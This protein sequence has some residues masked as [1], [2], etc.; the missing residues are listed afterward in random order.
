[1]TPY[2]CLHVLAVLSAVS[3][4]LWQANSHLSTSLLTKH[5]GRVSASADVGFQTSDKYTMRERFGVGGGVPDGLPFGWRFTWGYADN[6]SSAGF[7]FYPMVNHVRM[8]QSLAKEDDYPL[9]LVENPNLA[10]DAWFLSDPACSLLADKVATE[11]G[12]NPIRYA[13]GTRWIIGNET[14]WDNK[15]T[16]EQYAR[17]FVHWKACI[18]AIGRKHGRQYQYGSGAMIGHLYFVPRDRDSGK[19]KDIYGNL[20]PCYP[21][22]DQANPPRAHLDDSAALQDPQLS[23]GYRYM[24][25]YLKVLTN[26]YN[27]APDFI[28]HH[29]YVCNVDWKH[30]YHNKEGYAPTRADGSYNP[31]AY[32]RMALSVLRVREIMKNNNLQHLD[33]IVNEVAP[34]SEPTELTPRDREEYMEMAVNYMATAR[35]VRIGNPQDNNRLV[36]K[37]AWFI[38]A[39]QPSSAGCGDGFNVLS[40]KKNEVIERNGPTSGDLSHL[41]IKYKA[42]YTHATRN[43][44]QDTDLTSP[45]SPPSTPITPPPSPSTPVPNL[46]GDLNSDGVVNAQDLALLVGSLY[47]TNC[48]FVLSPTNQSCLITIADYNE[49]ISTLRD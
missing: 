32:D 33:L 21:L 48:S 46:T 14:G 13:D 9:S 39:C 38:G 47:T 35:D 19:A 1:M 45:I 17:A 41:G 6:R 2:R 12:K 5:A 36:Q 8:N 31:V 26:Q 18:S 49:L 11:I 29:L 40:L 23:T 20:L 43:D 37:W 24:D 4:G 28:T 27:E 15:Q 34:L 25:T 44:P 3:L 16:P 7:D 10:D 42:L 30:V 22:Y